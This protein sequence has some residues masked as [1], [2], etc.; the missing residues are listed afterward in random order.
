VDEKLIKLNQDI[1]NN[2]DS[3]KLY[4]ERAQI[5]FDMEEYKKC[6]ADCKKAI[7]L[8]DK[9][10]VAYVLLSCAYNILKEHDK[11][12]VNF[13]KAIELNEKDASAYYNRGSL[14]VDINE[15][16]KALADFNKAIEL[17]EKDASAYYNRGTLYGNIEEYD[18]ALADF[19]KAIELNENYVFAYNNRGTLYGDI[20]EY[21]KALA[22]FNKAIELNEN[23]APAYYNRGILYRNLKDYN[24][25]LA[26]FNKAIELNE[27]YVFAYNNRG[28]LYGDIKEYDKALADFN[29]A[30]ELNENYASTYYN[31][32]VLYGNLK[33]HNK[34]LA[35]FNKA[36]ELDGSYASAYNNRGT[37][38]GNIEEYDKALADFNKAIELDENNVSAYNNRGTLYG[39]IEEYD[40]A[41]A[42]FNKAIALDENYAS[43]Y[44]NRGTLYCDIKEYDKAL[45]DFNKAIELDE[46]N[47]SAYNNRGTL[48]DDIKDYDKAL[49]DYNKAIELDENCASAYNNRGALYDDIKDYDKALADYSKAIELDKNYALAYANRADIYYEIHR[50]NEKALKDFEESKK[51]YQEKDNFQMIKWIDERI[52]EINGLRS[53]STAKTSK[54]TS[55]IKKIIDLINESDIEKNV[56]ETKNS[57]KTFIGENK[58]LYSEEKVEFVV[59]RRW[60]SYTPIIADN[61]RV[62]KGGG[63]FF[64][65]PNCGIVID[66]GFNFIDNF[67]AAGY[68]FHQIDHILITHAHNDHTADLESILTLLHQYNETI[69]GEFDDPEKDT[70]MSE[71]YSEYG[72][73]DEN[74][75]NRYEEIAKEK[76]LNSSR[77]KRIRIYM[78]SST[79][80]KYVSMLKLH[81]NTDYDVVLIKAEDKLPII[82][83]NSL[84]AKCIT[85]LEIVA[86]PAKHNDMFS[87]R[88]SVGF[89]FK[90][91]DFVLVYTGDTGV[92][93]NIEKQ[94][95][96]I[97][98]N[99]NKY[100]IILLA[101]LGGFKNYEKKFDAAK[102]I[103]EN[104]GRFYKNHLGRLGLARIVDLLKP[105]ICIISEFGEE[106]RDSR[107][108]LTEIF[109]KVF[110]DST[111]FFPA[112]I[113]LTFDVDRKMKLI[114]SINNTNK[115]ASYGF[116]PYSVAEVHE[117]RL[118][119]S[120]Q[121]YEVN[122]VT[123]KDLEEFLLKLYMRAALDV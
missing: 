54:E 52:S 42:D 9:D 38:Y 101:H 3:F 40:K 67:K 65:I 107:K 56:I 77:R 104:G 60:N 123:K 88:D 37:L 57:F 36:I 66:P 48:Y 16:D 8:D 80:T 86:I 61:Y 81:K 14:Y 91:K 46:N 41:L 122:R 20:K 118:D 7:S 98:K 90:F 59:L 25:A 2:P 10:A 70:I 18:K 23:Y 58:S 63:Y 75:R 74:D 29:K 89:I 24:K 15:Y 32:G 4:L 12:L 39:N 64:K 83:P 19:N 51:L 34:A 22:D 26:D 96:K 30:I 1:K 33:D 47:V 6:V 82:C 69:L 79:Y 43:A 27:N 62:S 35:D 109:Y 45:A 28:S 94:Y 5:Y 121:Y 99:Y 120:L 114:D 100:E 105:K 13:N 103:R 92:D 115:S 73:P 85:D 116:H 110:K 87:D 112:D 106:F 55:K 72:K 113:G 21:D 97:K 49:A 117:N 102:P 76:L 119:N 31:R 93:E 68:K 50:N 95:E 44:N 84:D 71:V 17:N 108:E 78:T 11:A 53:K 111:T